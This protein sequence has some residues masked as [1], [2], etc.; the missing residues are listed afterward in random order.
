MFTIIFIGVLV[1]LVEWGEQFILCI[2][3]LEYKCFYWQVG[4]GSLCYMGAMWM[5]ISQSCGALWSALSLPSN[6]ILRFC[7]NVLTEKVL[8]WLDMQKIWAFSVHIWH[9]VPF[10]IAC[11]LFFSLQIWIF[12]EIKRSKKQSP[13][14]C[15]RPLRMD[16]Y[17]LL[18]VKCSV[19]YLV[20]G[21]KSIQVSELLVLPIL[22]HE[23]PGSGWRQ[24]SAYDCKSASLHRG[25]LSFSP[26]IS[27]W[28]IMLKRK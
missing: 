24:N 18:I 20:L 12:E 28:Q 15:F 19:R 23:V 10:L 21:E 27:I 14:P 2:I 4:K 1:T 22:D 6:R 16:R 8:I 17:I 9:K 7:I 13:V 26:I 25:S 5:Q 3:C 11:F